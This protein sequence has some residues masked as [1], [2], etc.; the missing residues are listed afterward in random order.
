M[1]G[2]T[3]SAFFVSGSSVT[4]GLGNLF[5]AFGM[6]FTVAGLLV[7]RFVFRDLGSVAASFSVTA[8]FALL[9]IGG[10]LGW[11]LVNYALL[12]ALTST[13][14]FPFLV[15]SGLVFVVLG[16]QWAGL[17]GVAVGI[18]RL[19]SRFYQWTFQAGAVLSVLPYIGARAKS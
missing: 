12:A 10:I 5:N 4:V 16:I 15:L 17:I 2:V 18:W 14:P 19:G 8:V 3:S 13:G 9:V 6:G 7:F 1:F 11:A